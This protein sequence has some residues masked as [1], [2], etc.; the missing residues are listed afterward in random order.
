MP[1]LAALTHDGRVATFDLDGKEVWPSGS[2]RPI[3]AS[4]LVALSPIASADIAW[5]TTTPGIASAVGRGQLGPDEH[6]RRHFRSLHEGFK[7]E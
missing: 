4:A 2:P 7:E 1:T 6:R 5:T 3:L